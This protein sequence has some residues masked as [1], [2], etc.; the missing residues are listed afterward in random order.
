LDLLLYVLDSF[1]DSLNCRQQI[2]ACARCAFSSL[3]LRRRLVAGRTCGFGNLLLDLLDDSL[4]L[5]LVQDLQHHWQQLVLVVADVLL[6]YP[7][8]LLDLRQER[9]AVLRR[10]R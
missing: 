9:L 1:R 5:I 8:Q 4:D 2:A 6:K 10:G 7:S 3:A